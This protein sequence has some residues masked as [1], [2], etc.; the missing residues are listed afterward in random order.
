MDLFSKSI[1][2]LFKKK[3]TCALEAGFQNK[4]G[5]ARKIRKTK[6]VLKSNGN[7]LSDFGLI[8]EISN[9]IKNNL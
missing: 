5:I 4:F 6:C 1:G 8:K 3:L 9:L 2:V 7:Q